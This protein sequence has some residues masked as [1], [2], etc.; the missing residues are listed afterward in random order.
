MYR[1]IIADDEFMIRQSL[2]TLVDW[3]SLGFEVVL[4]AR[5]GEEALQAL[6]GADVV[7]SD[8][9]MPKLT[10][11]DLAQ[12][13]FEEKL[14]VRVVLISGY[15]EFEYARRAIAYNV[16][17]Y[18]LKPI[19]LSGVKEVFGR[20]RADLDRERAERE[21]QQSYRDELQT[22]RAAAIEKF[23]ELARLGLFKEEKDASAYLNRFGLSAAL[24]PLL[25]YP[26]RLRIAQGSREEPIPQEVAANILSMLFEQHGFPLAP[27][28]FPDGEDGCEVLLLAQ[29]SLPDEK[30]R[31][32]CLD[33]AHAFRDVCAADAVLETAGPAQPLLAFARAPG[34][35]DARSRLDD[36]S[37]LLATARQHLI[38]LNTASEPEEVCASLTELFHLITK[39]DSEEERRRRARQ[40]LA[41]LCGLVEPQLPNFTSLF[42]SSAPKEEAASFDEWY[43]GELRRFCACMKQERRAHDSIVE[44][45]QSIIRSRISENVSLQQVADQVFISPNYLSRLFKEETGEN[46]SEFTIRVKMEKAAELLRDP[47]CRVYEVN[48]LLGYR[49]LQHFYKLFKRVFDCTPTEYREKILRVGTQE[50]HEKV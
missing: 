17:E 9:Q 28:L 40:L 16:S 46:F 27:I 11:L 32:L 6:S 26:Y 44:L 18:L 48:E 43:A 10:G 4:L 2:A 35:P 38:I 41:V 23:F 37:Y 22:Y 25:V 49:S 34:V 30:R 13:V 19:D 24:S 42:A 15:R 47:T 45:V 3:K 39:G 29:P 7:L 5:D 31:A 33:T 8:V 1:L 20:I 14:P 36:E 21:R 12:R 50:S